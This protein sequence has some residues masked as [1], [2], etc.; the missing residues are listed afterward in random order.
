MG[1]DA[2]GGEG[3]GKA[4]DDGEESLGEDDGVD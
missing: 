3:E 4:V 2:E 1:G